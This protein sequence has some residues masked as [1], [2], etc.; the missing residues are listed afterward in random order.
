M[1][2]KQEPWSCHD[3]RRPESP[4]TPFQA[5]AHMGAMQQSCIRCGVHRSPAALESDTRMRYQ[6]RCIDREACATARGGKS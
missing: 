4:G 2:R 6:K 3:K 5:A 1:T